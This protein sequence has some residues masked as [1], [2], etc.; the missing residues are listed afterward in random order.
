MNRYLK[1]T[2]KMNDVVDE[3]S[4]NKSTLKKFDKA[5][6][7]DWTIPTLTGNLAWDPFA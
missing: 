6:W 1:R 5:T 2:T 4:A 7:I 3:L